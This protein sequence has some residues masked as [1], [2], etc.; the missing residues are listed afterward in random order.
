MVVIVFG[1]FDRRL[2][3][4][5]TTMLQ[6]S[7]RARFQRNVLPRASTHVISNAPFIRSYRALDSYEYYPLMQKCT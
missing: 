1:A 4:T 7:F 2:D 6:P 5:Y 3:W